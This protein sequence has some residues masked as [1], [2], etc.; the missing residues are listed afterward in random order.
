MA[1]NRGNFLAWRAEGA[2]LASNLGED[3][4]WQSRHLR[5]VRSTS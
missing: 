1:L 3:D 2:R 5:S 4:R